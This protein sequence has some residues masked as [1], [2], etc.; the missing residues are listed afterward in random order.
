MRKEKALFDKD[1]LKVWHFLVPER[2]WHTVLLEQHMNT[3]LHVPLVVTFETDLYTE[4]VKV[5]LSCRSLGAVTDFR[6][7]VFARFD[8]PWPFS[9]RFMTLKFCGEVLKDK[10]ALFLCGTN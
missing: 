5:L 6:R 10:K 7:V 3:A 4:W 1:G 8:V 9:K 2:R